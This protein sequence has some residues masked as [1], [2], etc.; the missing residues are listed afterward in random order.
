MLVYVSFPAGII[1]I[2]LSLLSQVPQKVYA[3]V[4]GT[5]HNAVAEEMQALAATI[6]ED[7]ARDAAVTA[8]E[9][10]ENGG[11]ES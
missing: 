2:C 5:E 3:I 11:N 9:K 8:E 1:S 4:T 6:D 7:V 10:S